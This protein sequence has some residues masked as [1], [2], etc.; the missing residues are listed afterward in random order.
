MKPGQTY[1][2][3]DASTFLEKSKTQ[4][5]LDVRS[6][7]E[8][9]EG[10][11]PGAVNLPLFDDEER[12]E[13]GTLYK[14]SG[15][16]AAVLRGLKFAGAKM[17]DLVVQTTKETNGA[18]QVL[19]HC[20]RGGM[21]SQS[22][23]WLLATAGLEPTVLEGGYKAYRK[24]AN[25]FFEKDWRLQVVSG[26]TGAGKTRILKMLESAGEQVLD[27]EG[28]ANH[29]GSAFGGIGQSHQP[30]TE[31]F[32]NLAF[33]KLASF[34][35]AKTIWVEDEGHNV[36]SVVLPGSFYQSMR[37]APGIIFETT[38]EGRIQNL[39][40]DYG[41]LPA[42][43]LSQSVE[44]IRKRL[45][46]QNA[47][48]AQKAIEQGDIRKAIELVLNYYDKFYTKSTVNMPRPKMPTLMIEGLS[49]HQ[50]VQAAIELASL[51]KKAGAQVLPAS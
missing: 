11:I 15:R 22:V 37:H 33:Q 3:I 26:L 39:L 32:A 23:G 12:A 44:R 29:R 4:V 28:L 17:A 49:D 40:D 18:K 45:G 35:P 6:P 42:E 19:V 20:W 2:T 30:T 38:T 27:L 13:V 25:D 48:A 50:I 36:G 51:S 46:P 21:R 14:K 16:D 34:D 43:E 47:D 1:E 9:A 8:F 31:H 7:S 41:D 24:H 10:R 5:I